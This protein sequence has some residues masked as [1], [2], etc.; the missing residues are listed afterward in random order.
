MGSGHPWGGPRVGGVGRISGQPRCLWV[1]L[2]QLNS[3]RLACRSP[4]LQLH[5]GC[6]LQVATVL[7]QGPVQE[8]SMRQHSQVLLG[9]RHQPLPP[10]VG[11]W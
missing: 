3:P 11:G 7:R 4:A 6:A 10:V 8:A 9:P 2:Q 1:A 5:H